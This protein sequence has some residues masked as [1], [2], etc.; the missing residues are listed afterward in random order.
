MQIPYLDTWSMLLSGQVLM[1]PPKTDKIIE[2]LKMMQISYLDIWP[3][4]LSGQVLHTVL[5]IQVTYLGTSTTLC[6]FKHCTAGGK[7]I[8]T[9]Y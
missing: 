3:M 1:N 7:K 8:T 4:L 6:K 9:Y 2:R 5:G